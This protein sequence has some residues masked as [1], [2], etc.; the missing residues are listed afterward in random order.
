[1]RSKDIPVVIAVMCAIGFQACNQSPTSPSP[2]ATSPTSPAPPTSP[3]A[4]SL[5]TNWLVTQR[6]VSVSGPDNC[7]VREQRAR[8]TG[9]TF[10]D[11]PMRV[12]RSGGSVTLQ[13]DFF[14]V[15]YVGTISGTEFSATGGPLDGGGRPCQDG[16]SIQQNPGVSSLSGR[17]SADDQALTATEVNSYVLTSREPVTYVWEWQATRQHVASGRST[18]FLFESGQRTSRRAQ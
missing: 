4:S 12:T 3:P 6:F 16:T 15:N 11:L 2:P 18:S 17:F 13:G 5:V 1:M 8:W 9:A 14:Q 7:W 10:P